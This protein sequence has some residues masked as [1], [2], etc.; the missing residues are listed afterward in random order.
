MATYIKCIIGGEMQRKVNK[1]I[2]DN[3]LFDKYDKLV[4]GLSGGADSVALM[5]VLLRL[6]YDCVAAH[7]NF[8]LRGEESD[9][10]AEFVREWCKGRGVSLKTIDF[11]TYKYAEDNKISI[12][13]AARD[14][15][16]NWFEELRVNHKADYIAVAHH[17]NDSI[18]TLLINLIR[19]T[20]ISGLSGIEPKNGRVVRPLLAVNREDIEN[21]L[22]T[23]YISYRTDSTNLQDIYTRN[24][25]R[26]NILPA[27]QKLNPSVYDAMMRTANNLREVEKVYDAAIDADMREVVSNNLI[28]IEK[29]KVVAS[30]K[31]L[32]FEILFP[33]G[34]T[35][36]DIDD[37]WE[38][39]GATSGKIFFS[40]S[41]RLIRDRDFFI[42]DELEDISSQDGVYYIDRD[43]SIVTVPIN[44]SV[45]FKQ[46]PVSIIKSSNYLFVD[47]DKLT[48]PLVLRKWQKGDWFVPFGMK[49]KKKLS[50]FFS[51]QKFSLKDKEDVWILASGDDV[52]WIVGHRSDNRFRISDET[53]SVLIVH[54]K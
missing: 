45:D 9:Q 52:V 26:L 40:Q 28:D 29:L 35:S 15:R 53:K 11:D 7:C 49:G 8:H 25:I 31:S 48:F 12:E 17:Q 39:V 36:S 4:V 16:Y 32:L 30:P 19:G 46:A 43:D 34:F 10:D 37:V 42:I 1:F 47:A 22:N 27:M 5:E 44:M 24:Y 13:M 41:H 50:D 18:E 23:N 6:G 21:Y 20:G 54:I 2:L 14:L 33:L 3:E 38:S 51:D